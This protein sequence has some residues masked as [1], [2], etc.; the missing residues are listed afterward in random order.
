M[1]YKPTSPQV[2]ACTHK[3]CMAPNETCIGKT[4]Q[5]ETVR[6]P[7]PLCAH[8]SST[9]MTSVLWYLPMAWPKQSSARRVQKAK[10]VTSSSSQIDLMTTSP[11][12]YTICCCCTRPGTPCA[13]PY[14]AWARQVLLSQQPIHH[15]TS[16]PYPRTFWHMYTKPSLPMCW[17]LLV[18]IYHGWHYAIEVPH[19]IQKWAI[20]SCH[21]LV[22]CH[23]ALHCIMTLSGFPTAPICLINLEDPPH[24]RG[25]LA[26]RWFVLPVSACTTM[27]KW[28]IG[29]HFLCNATTPTGWS[30]CPMMPTHEK[31][32][33][34]WI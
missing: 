19:T 16:P 8:A 1:C 12:N 7:S 23:I 13:R 18:T 25:L 24:T 9:P 10:N 5:H 20:E 32:W 6:Y 21:F 29:P 2:I 14:Y 3:L 34:I 31:R 22:F 28:P 15:P 11:P 17:L 27:S 26:I 4:P 30:D 33:Y